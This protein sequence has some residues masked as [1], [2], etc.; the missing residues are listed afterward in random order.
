MLII[1]MF[2]VIPKFKNVKYHEL[3]PFYRVG[4]VRNIALRSSPEY[5]LE[6]RETSIAFSVLDSQGKL[7]EYFVEWT[8]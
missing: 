8:P 4:K 5:L 7:F 3:I 6:M 2:S 1:K